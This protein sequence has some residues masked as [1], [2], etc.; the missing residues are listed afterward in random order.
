MRWYVSDSWKQHEST[1]YFYHRGWAK[2]VYFVAS[3]NSPRMCMPH[4]VPLSPSRLIQRHL[5]G[6]IALSLVGT[7][8]LQWGLYC[9]GTVVCFMQLRQSWWLRFCHWQFWNCHSSK[10][11][12]LVPSLMGCSSAFDRS[13]IGLA[14]SSFPIQSRKVRVCDP[15]PQ[16]VDIGSLQSETVLPNHC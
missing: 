5:S 7:S 14:V 1:R 9:S 12:W 15:T 2:A 8:F 3:S 16:R 6:S 10:F 4:Q 13:G 11:C